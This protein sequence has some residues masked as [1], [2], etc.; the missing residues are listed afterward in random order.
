MHHSSKI[1]IA[2]AFVGAACLGFTFK[3]QAGSMVRWMLCVVKSGFV[4]QIGLSGSFPN[5]M[6][7]AETTLLLTHHCTRHFSSGYVV[8]HQDITYKQSTSYLLM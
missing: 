6:S 5:S 4:S 7:E 2:W 3:V 8:T 1:V